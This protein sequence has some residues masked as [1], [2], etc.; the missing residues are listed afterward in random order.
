MKPLHRMNPLRTGWVAERIAR[1]HR[2]AV[3]IQRVA[4][5]AQSGRCARD[6]FWAAAALGR[7]WMEDHLAYAQPIGALAFVQ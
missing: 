2:G 6:S 7:T 1:A 4:D 5:A 3:A